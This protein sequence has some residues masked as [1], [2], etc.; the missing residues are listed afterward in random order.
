MANVLIIGANRGIGLALTTAYANRGDRV[1]GTSRTG[2]STIESAGGHPIDGV[3]VT[4]EEGADTLRSALEG[5]QIDLAIIN[6]GLLARTPLENLDF[7]TVARQIEVNAIGALRMAH[8]ILPSLTEGSKLGIVTSRMGS[9]A[10]NTS[11]GGYG[12]RMSKAAVNS[13]GKSLSID[14]EPRGIAVR[15]LHPGWVRTEMTG[16]TGHVS[17]EEAASGLIQRMDELTLQTTGEFWH[18]QGTPLPW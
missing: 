17:A 5:I 8:C 14:L 3:D 7:G 2:S 15:L 11:G 16:G 9:I 10:D 12:Y 13:V 4:K 18:A 6:A 1:Y